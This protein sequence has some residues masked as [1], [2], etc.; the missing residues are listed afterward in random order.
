M[1]ESAM[2]NDNQWNDIIKRKLMIV[3]NDING[4]NNEKRNN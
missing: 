2:R 1:K 4:V 3:I